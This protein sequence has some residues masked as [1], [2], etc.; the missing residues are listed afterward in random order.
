MNKFNIINASTG[1]Q[2]YI[3]NNNLSS[4]RDIGDLTIASIAK[5]ELANTKPG[6]KRFNYSQFSPNVALNYISFK[7]GHKFN[8]FINDVLKN[9]VPDL[10]A[11]IIILH[12]SL[13][14]N[15]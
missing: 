10:L 3:W 2:K 4:G 8:S 7:T 12:L 14:D 9:H 11:V 13:L 1:D 5:K 6:K 15:V